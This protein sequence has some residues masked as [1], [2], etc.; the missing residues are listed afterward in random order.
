MLDH[1]LFRSLSDQN[2]TDSSEEKEM[3]LKQNL[4]VLA[5]KY[6]TTI[7]FAFHTREL[8]EVPLC[9]VPGYTSSVTAALADESKPRYSPSANQRP[10]AC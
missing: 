10:K 8:I 6:I 4:D 5:L 7:S 2:L 3:I 9:L 1:S